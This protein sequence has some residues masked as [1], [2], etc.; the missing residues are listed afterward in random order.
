LVLSSQQAL[1]FC[2]NI[3]TK[4]RLEN[5]RSSA[6]CSGGCA[7]PEGSPPARAAASMSPAGAALSKAARAI[8][9]RIRQQRTG[10]NGQDC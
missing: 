3:G 1:E 10:C 6:D 4:R 9:D 2:N 7:T 5:V 8:K